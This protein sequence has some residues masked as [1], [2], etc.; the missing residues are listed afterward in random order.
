MT[1]LVTRLKHN[2]D[3]YAD[4]R[5]G[6]LLEEA[7]VEIARLTAITS[8]HDAARAHYDTARAH[9]DAEI[10]RLKAEL[11]RLVDSHIATTKME[12]ERC[13]KEAENCGAIWVANA[14]RGKT[15]E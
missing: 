2:A 10:E 6:D 14:I 5:V 12:T 7:A 11:D 8:H 15:D 13:A 1:D 3:R 9:Y 4:Y